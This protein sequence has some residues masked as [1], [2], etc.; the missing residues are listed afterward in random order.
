MTRAAVV[1]CGDIS[2]VHLAAIEAMDDV[3]LVGVCDADRAR[4]AE[5][6]QRLRV[7]AL[8]DHRRLLEEL[9]PDVVH[10]CTPHDQHAPVAL[11]CLDAGVAVLLEKPVAHTVP[12]ALRVVEAAAAHPD[13]KIGVC[14]QNRY[15]TPVQALR[16]LVDSGDLG[17]VHG[18]SASVLW[19]RTPAYYAA[20]PWRGRRE[21][22]GGGVLINQAIHTLDLVQ[23]LVG[24]VVRV[25]GRAGTYEL[26]DVIDVEDTATLVLDHAG[27][28]RS[29]FVATVTNAVDAPVTIDLATE[30]A[31]VQLRQDLVVR[32]ADGRV[33]TVGEGSVVTAGRA[34]WGASHGRLVEDFYARL[35]EP[36]PFWIG[37]REAL[38]SLSIIDA[39]YAEGLDRP[40]TVPTPD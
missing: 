24:D 36:E 38:A 26:A 8:D 27:G 37:P 23:W 30:H 17:T 18:A 9:R 19:H 33:D 3:E 14:L 25:R 15:N 16:Q 28:A 22:S 4:A 10:V 13:V 7:P 6:G 31:T 34:Y 35:Q 20:R 21:R 11:D 40:G 5:V 39:V 32:W 12:E 1:G 2:V 29:V